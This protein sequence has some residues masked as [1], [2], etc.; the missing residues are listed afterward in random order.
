MRELFVQRNSDGLKQFA[1]ETSLQ[2]LQNN[3]RRL[4]QFSIVSYSLAKLMEKP[5]IVHSSRWAK[6]SKFLLQKLAQADK[7]DEASKTCDDALFAIVSELRD[8]SSD[9]G[10]FVFNVVEKAKV[11]AATEI[12]CHGASIGVAIELTGADRKELMSYIGGM[13]LADKF[14]TKTV[15]QR[16][17]RVEKLFKK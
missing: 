6:F 5:Y 9:L 11:K 14:E 12:Y 3:D 15:S 7:C 8:L 2:A 13:T 10:R 4:V 17:T 1:V 16:L